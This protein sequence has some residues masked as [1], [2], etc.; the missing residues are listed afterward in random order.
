M[1]KFNDE[2]NERNQGQ[3]V[4]QKIY[5]KDAS[6]EGK[7]TPQVFQ[8]PWEPQIELALN[9]GS[10]LLAQEVYEVILSLTVTAKIKEQIAFLVEVHMAGIFLIQSFSED[11]L[12]HLLGAYCLEVI[13]P[14][15]R[16]AISD[17]VVRGGF[18]QLMLTPMNFDLIYKRSQEQSASTQ[19]NQ[20]SH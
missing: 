10:L 4:I 16:E 6:F 17:L 3:L 2:I 14:Y 11:E 9:S 15:A 19:V 8:Q 20:E 5:L 12:N 1:E 7:N 13:Y 18:P